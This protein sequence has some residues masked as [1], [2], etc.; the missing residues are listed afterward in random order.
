MATPGSPDE[1]LDRLQSL[2]QELDDLYGHLGLPKPKF[3][4]LTVR[5]LKSTGS[6]RDPEHRVPTRSLRR[7]A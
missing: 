6:L 7:G 5:R 1:H 3:G 2:E 4:E